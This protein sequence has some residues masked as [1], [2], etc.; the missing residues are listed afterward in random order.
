MWIRSQKKR[1]SA[2]LLLLS[3]VV[4]LNVFWF[5][6][7][8]GLTLAGDASCGI[9]EHTHDELCETKHCICEIP[10]EAHCHDESCYALQWVDE[11]EEVRLICEPP[12]L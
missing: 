10:E 8:P 7:Q 1:I 12:P 3:F 4:T 2:T 11:R 6:R 5:L 9:Q